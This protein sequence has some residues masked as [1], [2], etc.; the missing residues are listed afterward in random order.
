MA[1]VTG[2][3]SGIGAAFAAALPT[4]TGLLLTG[5]RNDRL[6][7]LAEQLRGEGR[8]VDIMPVDLTVA[9]DRR[10]LTDRAEA[11]SVDLLI[12]NAGFGAFGR[13]VENDPDTELAMIDVNVTAVVDLTRHLLPGMVARAK[14]DSRRAGLIIVSSTVSFT[15]LPLLATYAATKAFEISFADALA[16]EMRG[17]P[18][19]ILAM[20]PG[21]TR[22]RFFERAGMPDKF[23]R[24]AES[25]EAVAQKALRALGR[26]RLLVS[27]G[28]FRM[29]LSPMTLPRRAAVTGLGWAMRGVIRR[30]E[31]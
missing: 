15:P 29:A 26:R 4:T 3:S 25:P 18:V 11:L 31:P 13:F 10:A 28:A 14:R 1:L 12:N 17:D 30:R 20:C 23:L 2:A 7:T 6:E 5:R 9:A 16:E 19:D 22:T 8:T 24:Y 21:A 27:R